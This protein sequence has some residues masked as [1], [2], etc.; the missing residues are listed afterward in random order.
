MM[1]L[2]YAI[3]FQCLLRFNEVLILKHYHLNFL[4]ENDDK[5]NINL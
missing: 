3:I 4:N 1:S 5:L 2:I